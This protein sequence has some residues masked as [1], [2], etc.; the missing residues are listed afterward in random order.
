MR[1]EKLNVADQLLGKEVI[2]FGSRVEVN[3][4]IM[5][6]YEE[7][8]DAGQQYAFTGIVVGGPNTV[9]SDDSQSVNIMP[10]EA[11][12]IESSFATL[13][14]RTFNREPYWMVLPDNTKVLLKYI[15]SVSCLPHH[16]LAESSFFSQS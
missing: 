1:M 6:N 2:E 12:P 8:R 16:W 5:N 3:L 14:P 13:H 4:M 10:D 11:Q 15:I 9:G 7:W